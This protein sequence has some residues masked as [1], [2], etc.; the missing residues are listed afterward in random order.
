[1]REFFKHSRRSRASLTFFKERLAKLPEKVE[2]FLSTVEYAKSNPEVVQRKLQQV[3]WCVV[4]FWW[5]SL[6]RCTAHSVHVVCCIPFCTTVL[7]LKSDI[8]LELHQ[9]MIAQVSFFQASAAQR[10][11]LAHSPYLLT[12]SGV[13]AQP[14]RATLPLCTV[15]WWLTRATHTSA[16]G[17][18]TVPLIDSPTV[19][20]RRSVYA[21]WRY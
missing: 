3:A 9:P 21:A 10:Q 8:A 11:R 14:L 13:A 16:V 17:H 20:I 1:M 7:Q 6:R 12:P 2:S 15:R 18:R 19:R 4:G 5:V